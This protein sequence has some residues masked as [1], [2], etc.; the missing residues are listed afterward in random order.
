MA[1]KEKK[2]VNS[3]VWMALSDWD[4]NTELESSLAENIQA[5]FE[6]MEQKKL[7]YTGTLPE[8]N[9]QLAIRRVANNP[10]KLRVHVKRFYLAILCRSEKKLLGALIDLL[11]ALRSRGKPLSL[12]LIE[13]AGIILGASL[14][15]QLKKIVEDQSLKGILELDFSGSVLM[16]GCSLPVIYPNKEQY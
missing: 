11:I 15:E 5:A 1:I 3:P 13:E 7:I 9:L 4:I 2:V 8:M 10:V 6:S 14:C 12:R 16:N